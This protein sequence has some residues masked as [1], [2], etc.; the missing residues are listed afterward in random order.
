MEEVIDNNMLPMFILEVIDSLIGGLGTTIS[1]H[2]SGYILNNSL[3]AFINKSGSGK[4]T[5]LLYALKNF[6]NCSY[7]A[8]DKICVDEMLNVSGLPNAVKIKPGTKNLFQINSKN[9]CINK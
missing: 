7:F 8:D 3:T 1:F 5:A 6:K 4:S 9:K 2:A